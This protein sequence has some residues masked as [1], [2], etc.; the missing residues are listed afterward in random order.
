[1]KFTK[2]AHRARSSDHGSAH[3]AIIKYLLRYPTTGHLSLKYTHEI[4]R[5]FRSSRCLSEQLGNGEFSGAVGISLTAFLESENSSKIENRQIQSISSNHISMTMTISADPKKSTD[6]ND[7]YQNT[8]VWS[9][10][11][12]I[13]I[14]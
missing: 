5:N 13:S 2:R 10:F 6:R 7:T 12:L 9:G 1:M 14:S 8:F 11:N 3:T 4:V